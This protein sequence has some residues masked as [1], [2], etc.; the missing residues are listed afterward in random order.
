MLA[1]QRALEVPIEHI[2]PFKLKLT[3]Q[4]QQN[5]I[6]NLQMLFDSG[7]YHYGNEENKVR[8]AWNACNRE[9]RN[10]WS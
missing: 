4:D 1:E 2:P 8:A 3:L 5:W 6:N 9:V 10:K 7:Q